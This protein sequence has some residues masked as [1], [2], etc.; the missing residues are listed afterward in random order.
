MKIVRLK[1]ADAL[2]LFA[3]LAQQHPG[4]VIDIP[5]TVEMRRAT[6]LNQGAAEDAYSEPPKVLALREVYPNLPYDVVA[7]GGEPA[8][9]E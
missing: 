8:K 3:R 5:D 9:G 7:A 6:M 1:T 4:C 2:K